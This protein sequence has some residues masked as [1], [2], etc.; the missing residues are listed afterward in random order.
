MITVAVLI[1]VL[2]V[3]L[4]NMREFALVAVWALVAIFIRHKDQYESIAYYAILG[5]VVLVIITMLHALKNKATAP[6]LKFKE[7][8][9]DN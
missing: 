1:N 4:R 6:H 2:M 9:L 7:R 8:F 5:A 3:W